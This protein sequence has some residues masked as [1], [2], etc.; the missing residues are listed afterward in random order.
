MQALRPFPPLLLHV[1]I[2]NVTVERVGQ[3]TFFPCWFIKLELEK[4]AT[5]EPDC[6]VCGHS[7]SL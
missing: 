2:L 1:F 3:E 6:T 4:H 5:R 7:L